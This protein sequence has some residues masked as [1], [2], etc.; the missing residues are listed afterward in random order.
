[1]RANSPGSAT[2]ETGRRAEIDR[3][4]T[5]SFLDP[6][7][8]A[9]LTSGAMSTLELSPAASSTQDAP[10]FLLLTIHKAGSSYVGEVFKEIFA[11]H[12]YGIVDPLTEAFDRG[13]R[14]GPYL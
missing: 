8:V 7:G 2:S 13:L 6:S 11:H 4:E 14:L 12:G 10:S 9:A 3:Q 5:V 1:M